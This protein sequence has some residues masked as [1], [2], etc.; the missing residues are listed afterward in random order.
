MKEYEFRY[1]LK[2]LLYCFKGGIADVTSQSMF[3]I[4]P[5]LAAVS[6]NSI[7]LTWE[8]F[9]WSLGLE[10]VV[11]C[12]IPSDSKP[13]EWLVLLKSLLVLFSITLDCWISAVF[14]VICSLGFVSLDV[15]GTEWSLVPSYHWI[16][17]QVKPFC[18]R[19]QMFS[20]HLSADV[21]SNVSLP[22]L[23][24]RQLLTYLP[25]MFLRSCFK[26][27]KNDAIWPTALVCNH[28]R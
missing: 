21:V 13:V 11:R 10:A 14:S 12:L 6:S 18:V 26:N 16:Y 5:F 24:R 2:I 17:Y 1:F 22:R 3:W 8:L 7:L 20:C 9:C 23:F 19:L 28:R 4:D 15:T 27:K 25:F